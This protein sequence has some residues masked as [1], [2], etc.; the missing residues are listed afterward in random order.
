MDAEERQKRIS[1]GRV[2]KDFL[3]DE[4][5]KAVF[6]HVGNDLFAKWYS[7]DKAE[8]ARD[9]WLKAR[10]LRLLRDQ[11]TVIVSQGKTAQ[12]DA[13]RED[14]EDR[15]GFGSKPTIGKKLRHRPRT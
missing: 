15:E 11:M 13:E 1:Q 10:G 3:E 9:L 5:T 8:E 14:D 6:Q 4:R 7:T 2:F 12:D